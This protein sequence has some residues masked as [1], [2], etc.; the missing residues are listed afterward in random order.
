MLLEL[1]CLRYTT[2]DKEKIAYLKSIGAVEID[3]PYTKN[4]ND[5]SDTKIDDDYDNMKIDEL[6]KIRCVCSDTG[7]IL[8]SNINCKI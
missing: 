6:K 5:G 7:C 2:D 1:N 3:S 4:D 8:N